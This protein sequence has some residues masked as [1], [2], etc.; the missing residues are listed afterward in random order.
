MSQDQAILF[1]PATLGALTLK[2]HVVMAPLTRSRAIGNTPNE[3]MATYYGQRAEAG[4]IITE[5]TSPAPEGL[6]YARIPGLFNADQVAGWKLVTD[7]VHARGGRIFVQFMHTGRISHPLNLPAGAE[8][9]A[10][11]ALAAA[12]EMWTDQQQLQPQPTPRA[13]TTAEVKD[14][15]QQ[16]AASAKLAIEAG[17]DGVELHGANG[18]LIEQFL[19]PAAN[20]RTDEY[21]GSVENRNRFALEVARATIA[22]I[23]ADKVGIRLSPYGLAGDL[24][25]FAELDEQYLA[26]AGQLQQLNLVYVHLVDHSSMGAPKVPAE[27]VAGIRERFTN[28]LILSGG[29]DK[30][31]AEA[32]LQSG[33]ADLVAFGR[34]FIANPDLVTRLQQD[35][36]L[37]QPNPE[38]FYT[39]GPEGYTDYPTLAKQNA[40]A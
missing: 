16:H 13:L 23:G 4:L 25:P 31:R 7:A 6:G 17:F 10:P 24:K 14:L 20:Q 30:Q 35:A 2:N 12:G 21:G 34:P 37:A 29:Y 26:L 38:K 9:V 8:I 33:K 1:S 39:P 40:T 36:E 28:T 32:D 19:N 11:S 22:A 5:G 15:V 27:L 3:L 18:Y